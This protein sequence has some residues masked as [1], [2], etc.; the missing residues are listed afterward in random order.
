MAVVVEVA[1][2]VGIGVCMGWGWICSMASCPQNVKTVME[3]T[4]LNTK[5]Y[6]II[7]P[8]LFIYTTE[9]YFQLE[10]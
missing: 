2:G 5:H 9:K 1:T 4:F 6:Y 3:N 10:N 7:F 8:P